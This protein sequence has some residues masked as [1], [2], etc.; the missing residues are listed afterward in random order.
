MQDNLMDL[1]GISINFCQG[2]PT[3]AYREDA[4][5]TKQRRLLRPFPFVDIVKKMYYNES[6]Y[7]IIVSI[8]RWTTTRYEG[9]A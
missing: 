3:D 9:K 7:W 8:F 2:Y 5:R 6:I 1:K 4:K